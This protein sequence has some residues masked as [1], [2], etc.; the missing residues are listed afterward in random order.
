MVLSRE[1]KEKTVLDLYYNKGY[2]YKQITR[3]LRMS[4]NQIREILRKQ[5]EKNDTIANKKKMLSLS[6]Q[7]YKLFSEGKNNVQAAIKMDLPQERITQFRLEYWRLQNQDELES[8][9]MLT[10]NK[11]SVLWKIY[12]ELMVV[13][14][15]SIEEV[16]NVI[17]T[18]IMFQLTRLYRE[19]VKKRGMSIE[20]VAAVVDVALN[21]LPYMKEMLEQ[22]SKLLARK[23][24][25][26]DM[27]EARINSLKE[28]E[29]RRRNRIFTLPSSS[30]Y[31]ENS[32]TNTTP[33]YSAPS[34]SPSLPYWPS[35]NRDPWSE[36]R[37]KEKTKSRYT[38]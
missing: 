15:M 9:Y 1:E 20:E 7:A 3:E 31:V 4:P 17:S 12:K 25:E 29:N 13:W 6:S 16:G 10:K 18:G 8:L 38:L 22:T 19:L 35:G 27:L 26:L 11:V 28:E 23:Q 30:Y 36:Y 2:T 34:Q 33:Y 5:E 32:S 37:D 24:V 14:G 21:K